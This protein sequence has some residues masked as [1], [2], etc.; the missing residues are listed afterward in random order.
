[1]AC[2]RRTG[3]VF[4]AQARFPDAAATVEGESRD[5]M[6]RGDEGGEV[7][8]HFC[9]NCGSTVY[10]RLDAISGFTSVAIGA[11]ADPAFPPP[12]VS[13]YDEHRCHWLRFDTETR[14]V[15]E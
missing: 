14:I 4:G 1:M 2:R 8:S 15:L 12:Q 11:F 10:W 13:V 7:T 5:F 3:S 9:P 6:R